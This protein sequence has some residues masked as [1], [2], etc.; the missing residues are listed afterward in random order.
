MKH[1]YR[2]GQMLEMRSSTKLTTQPAGLCEVVF[3][4]PHE[5][6]TLLYRVNSLGEKIE[7][8]VAETDLSPSTASRPFPKDAAP[9]T[10]VAITRR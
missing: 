1:R 2:V 9:K 3:C 6:G 5:N 10:G 4:L 8:V 7:R